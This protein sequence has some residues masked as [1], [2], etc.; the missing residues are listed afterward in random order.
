MVSG[1]QVV[2]LGDVPWWQASLFFPSPAQFLFYR[3]LYELMATGVTAEQL[4]QL[5]G[6]VKDGMR[7]EL[8]SLK[9]ELTSDR[10]A[11]DD[12]LP[13]T[14]EGADIQEEG[15]RETIRIQRRSVFEGRGSHRSVGG[16]TSS[17]G[18][19]KDPPRRR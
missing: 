12:R 15:A 17:C 6:A 4:A 11:T 3:L 7:E 9:R 14:G 1:K 8:S 5:L 18:E 2:T 13:K 10:Q 16:D 19:S